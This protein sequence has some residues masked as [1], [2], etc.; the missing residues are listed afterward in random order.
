M[1]DWGAI[2]GFRGKGL[3][4]SRGAIPTFVGS[5]SGFRGER[6]GLSRGGGVGWGGRGCGLWWNGVGSLPTHFMKIRN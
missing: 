3:G 2:L 1:S 6:S 5:D 4:L